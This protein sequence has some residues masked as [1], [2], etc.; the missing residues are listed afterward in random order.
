LFC[1]IRSSVEGGN[2]CSSGQLLV[3]NLSTTVEYRVT[4]NIQ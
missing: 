2:K 4:G 3:M 1:I